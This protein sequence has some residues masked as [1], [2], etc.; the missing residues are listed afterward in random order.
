[1]MVIRRLK[2]KIIVQCRCNVQINR[3]HFCF[4]CHLDSAGSE[5]KFD[6]HGDG[7]AR[8]EILNFQ[9]A[10]QSGSNGYY[11]RVLSLSCNTDLK[12]SATA[13]PRCA[14]SDRVITI[15]NLIGGTLLSRR[16]L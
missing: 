10:N 1:M 14:E 2:T 4:L 12:K 3:W 9:K 15:L 5:V 13:T 8:Y 6:E 7:L 11:Y 16:V